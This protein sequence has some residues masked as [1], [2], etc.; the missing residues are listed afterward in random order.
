MGRESKELEQVLPHGTSWSWRLFAVC[1]LHVYVLQL[2]KEQPQI[3]GCKASGAC[4]GRNC[5]GLRA[6]IV[7]ALNVL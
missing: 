6:F 5:A 3:I 1:F 7:F 2:Q 4:N